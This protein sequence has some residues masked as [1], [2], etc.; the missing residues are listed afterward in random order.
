MRRFALALLLAAIAQPSAA[1]PPGWAHQAVG[2]LSLDAPAGAALKRVAPQ[3]WEL[4]DRRMTLGVAYGPNVADADDAEPRR[5]YAT[6]IVL[7]DGTAGVLRT[8]RPTA[9][10]DC[11]E[12]Y[13]SLYVPSPRPGEA[14]LFLWAWSQDVQDLATVRAVIAS[15]RIAK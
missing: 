10:I 14:A 8:T 4:H 2:A 12:S 7:F 5:C 9:R 3:T 6:E 1:A 11:P 15:I 13:A